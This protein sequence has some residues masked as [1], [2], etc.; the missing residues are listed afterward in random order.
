MRISKLIIV[1]NINKLMNKALRLMAIPILLSTTALIAQENKKDPYLLTGTYTDGGSK[2]IYVS[3][4]N[5]QTG[6]VTP[7]S[8]TESSNPSFLAIAA[9]GEHVYAVNENGKDD[10]GGG[11]S[12]YRFNKATGILTLLNTQLSGGD[13]PCFAEVDKTG[14]WLF[15]GNYGSGTL[16]LFPITAD[17]SLGTAKLTIK[18]QGSGPDTSR[19]ASPHV[20][21]TNLTPD[22]KW[23]LVGDLGIDKIMIYSFNAE[24]GDLKPADSPSAESL[25]GSGPRHIA[26]APS[27]PYLYLIEE[28]K[29]NI[30]TY[31]YQDGKLKQLQRT[32]TTKKGTKGFPGSADIH[33]SPDGR[34]LYATNRGDFD[35]IATYKI[36]QQ[37]GLLTSIEFQSVMGKNPRNFS[38]DP[39][40][41]YLLVANQSS[42]D[43]VLF[44]RDAKTGKLTATGDTV[45]VSKPVC[46]K[47]IAQ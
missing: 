14:R 40:G 30:T 31:H 36:D 1:S 22:N 38:I 23:L 35:N 26:F 6:K 8:S 16:T 37:T 17:G 2:G 5:A 29:G 15:V 10:N 7:V 13:Y 44:K 19:Q 46:L 3:T 4:F 20:H 45:Q 34:F 25:A 11:V 28:L 18:H 9:N 41:N 33:V 24:T 39:S 43:I 47:W 12:A 32:A 42:D 21:S 27:A